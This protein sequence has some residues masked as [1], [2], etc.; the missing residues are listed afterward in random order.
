MAAIMPPV[1]PQLA[2]SHGSKSRVA[3]DAAL[4]LITVVWGLAFI[5]QKGAMAHLGP[6]AFVAARCYVG[7]LV[8]APFALRERKP[9]AGS[10]RRFGAITAA[11]GAAFLIAAWLQQAGVTTA[12][13]T[14]AGFL[15]GLYVV[16]TPLVAWVWTGRRPG[17]IVWPAVA[18][19]ALG[20]W[21]L[22]GGSLGSL[23]RGDLLV[24]L[25]ALFWAIHVVV[26]AE[27]AAYG[28][29][30]AFT[31][32]Q[33]LLVGVLATLGSAALETTT[34]DGLLAAAVDIAYVGVLSSGL[35]FAIM[36]IALRYTP[37][38][39]AAVI[40]SVEMLFA[41]LAAYLL[42][43]ERLPP[44]GWLGAALMLSATLL[45]HTAPLATALLRRSRR[46][47]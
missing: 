3:A 47:A 43:G 16:L 17:A 28:R 19:S 5:F 26:S 6:L 40:V 37:P 8:L 30:I 35:A 36:T 27:A 9:S 31:A 25:S 41:A 45:F 2:H 1:P 46:P 10:P 14:N 23:G 38:A 29:P 34:V 39:E 15:T 21:L 42:L 24:A 32:L 12:T 4:L 7:A 18:L 20:A 11:G 33:F 22:G 44:I 13:V